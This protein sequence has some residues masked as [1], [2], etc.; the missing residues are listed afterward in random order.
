MSG[1]E[2]GHR[3]VSGDAA[4]PDLTTLYYRVVH[5]DIATT[6]H[7]D[8]GALAF[9]NSACS[10][11]LGYDPGELARL[12][13][14]TV[15]HPDDADILAAA[16]ERAYTSLDGT[17]EDQLRLVRK[18][19]SAVTVDMVVHRVSVGERRYLMVQSTIV[20]R[21]SSVA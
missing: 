20:F 21:A 10:E 18:D 1:N 5:S 6:V 11:L 19:G 8:T 15:V 9:Y 2:D 7:D 13:S 14:A 16:T 4:H 17:A 3:S 12:Q